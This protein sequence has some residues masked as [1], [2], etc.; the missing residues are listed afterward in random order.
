M[1]SI[2][3]TSPPAL[4]EVWLIRHGETAWSRAGQ[5]TGR[6]D[7]A[8]TEHGREQA[9]AL[10]PLLAAQQFD[11]VLSSPMTR[12]IETCRLAGL[13]DR[14]QELPELHEWDYG[15]YEG[16]TTAEIRAS[17]PGWSVWHSQVPQGES[18]AQVQV[19]AS[20]VVARLLAMNGRI[21]VFSHAHFLR[22]LAGCWIGNEASLGAH[23][24]LDTASVSVLGFDRDSRAIRHWNT[25]H[26]ARA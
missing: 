11:A 4:H 25:R 15:I 1:S 16:R 21:V 3:V 26:D 17:A 12:A 8:L 13:D 23:L 10:A 22:A 9:R 14:R 18:L 2:P 24:Y 20:A 7:I 6:T 5:H 19:R